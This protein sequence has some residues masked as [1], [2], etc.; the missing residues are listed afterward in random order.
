MVWGSDTSS[1]IHVCGKTH[2]GVEHSPLWKW[3]Q[4]YI[5][6]YGTP[7][8]FGASTDAITQ[9]LLTYLL[10]TQICL[11]MNCCT[12]WSK[13]PHI[14]PNCMQSQ[15]WLMHIAVYSIHMWLVSQ[16]MI[17]K[18]ACL[19][20]AYIGFRF[21]KKLLLCQ[22]SVHTEVDWYFRHNLVVFGFV[23]VAYRRFINQKDTLI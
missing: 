6:I 20:T 23:S 15:Y 13:Y 3:V 16:N 11:K 4:I 14:L 9:H 21:K 12:S 19:F 7:T 1:I 10:F 5:Y 17:V 8:N 18:K 22:I 2:S